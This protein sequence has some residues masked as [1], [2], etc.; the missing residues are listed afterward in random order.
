[1]SRRIAVKT[2]LSQKVDYAT[3]GRM[4]RIESLELAFNLLCRVQ[5]NRYHTVTLCHGA[6][7]P[8]CVYTSQLSKRSEP[9][10]PL[11][12]EIKPLMYCAKLFPVSQTRVLIFWYTWPRL[13]KMHRRPEMFF[14]LK[15]RP[16]ETLGHLRKSKK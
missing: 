5:C 9:P 10:A 15:T 2:I 4:E 8:L 6:T 16:Q 12:L 11:R 13:A 14:L 1:M 3:G 7:V